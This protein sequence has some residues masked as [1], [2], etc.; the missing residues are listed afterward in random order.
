MR[1]FALLL[2]RRD[3]ELASLRIAA[4]AA[5]VVPAVFAL[6]HYLIGQAQTTI[7]SVFGSFAVL[8]LTEFGGP[9]R[10]RLL[11]YLGIAA[12]GLVLIPLGTLC[13]EMPVVA[14]AAMAAVGFT[15]LFSGLING[16]FAAGGFAALLAFILSTNVPAPVSAVPERLAGW[17]LACTVGISAAMLLWPARPRAEL[18]A[19]AARACEALA[20]LLDPEPSSPA[21]V[22]VGAAREAVAELRRRFL[23]T[24]YRPTGPSGSTEALAF[25]VDE[26]D[27]LG[28][29]VLPADGERQGT[30]LCRAE[31]REVLTAA[32]A[33]LRA[34]AASLDGLDALPDLDRLEAARDAVLEALVREV[35]D[36][37]A[38]S[39]DSVLLSALAPSFRMRELSFATG[40]IGAN[41]L[42]AVGRAAPDR[43]RSRR[44]AAAIAAVATLVAGHLSPQSVWFRNSVRGAAALAAATFVAQQASLQHA[45]WVVLGTLSVLR[46]NALGTGSTVVSALVGTA[47]GIVAGVGLILLIGTDLPV[48]WGVL[49]V[50]VLLAA[51]APRAISFAAGQAGFTVVVLVL[52][53]IIQPTGWTVGLVRVE[54]VAIGFAISLTVGLLLWP[55]GAGALVRHS[56]ADAFRRSADYVAGAVRA[57]ERG[58]ADAPVLSARRAARAAA[59]RLDDAVRQLLAERGADRL[60]PESVGTLV[61]GATRLQLAGHSLLTL[62]RMV[63]GAPPPERC[64]GALDADVDALRSWYVALGDTVERSAAAPA[65]ARDGGD[66]GRRVLRCAREAVADGDPAQIRAALGLLVASHHLDNLRRLELHLVETAA[67]LPVAARPRGWQGVL[68]IVG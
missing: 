39:D 65:E 27:W 22:R 18:R 49:P 30:M 6:A 10:A 16:F 24:P 67:R 11:A 46:S 50:A 64:A 55:R 19:P 36:L 23:A 57:L 54:D 52:F 29:L 1:P 34:A 33:V 20:D 60:E 35:G 59:N 25:L 37:E 17:A 61:A 9:R 41:A 45:F 14:T 38:T 31:N 43:D 4:R 28:A 66:G 7:F 21:A 8:V 62:A 51:Y 53:T 44:A 48:L 5:I 58:S 15:I 63:D 2:R 32:I 13:S 26:L 3:P 12:A 68:A 47:V 40:E 42:R 56:L